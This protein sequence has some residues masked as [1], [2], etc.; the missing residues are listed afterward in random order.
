MDNMFYRFS[1]FL[2]QIFIIIII[3]VIV[4]V[5]VIYQVL[6]HLQKF[7]NKAVRR[8]NANIKYIS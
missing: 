7:I 1:R 3:V 2:E 8:P 4:V 6:S 5:V